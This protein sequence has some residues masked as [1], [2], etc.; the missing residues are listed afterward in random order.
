MGHT[1]EGRPIKIAGRLI[2]PRRPCF[3][4]AEAGVNHNGDLALAKQLVDAAVTAG[5][6]AVKFQTFKAERLAS[7]SAP[8]AAYQLQTTDRSESQL[9]MLRRLELSEPAHR[10][11]MAYCQE[12]RI[13]FLSSPFEEESADVLEQLG[14]CAFK[15]PSGELTNLP[16]LEHVARKGKP[17]IVS[18]GMS[19]L[20]EVEQAVQAIR[21]MK[22]SQVVLLHCV[23]D[24]PADP[25][26]ANLRAMQTMADAFKVPVGYSDH[27]P[28]IEVALAAV[29]LGACV[30]EKHFTCDR[31][32]PGPDHRASLEPDELRRL[33]QGIRMV[34]SALGDGRKAPVPREANT[35]A[36]ARKSLVAARDIPAGSL[37]TEESIAIKRPGTGLPPA[38]LP[39]LVGRKTL[40][41]IPVDT[42]LTLETVG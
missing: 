25:S 42:L 13:L 40:R 2:G 31:T 15:I 19:T 6:D 33:V 24:Y 36:V 37:L 14:V 32:L 7:A 23:S 34:E 28:G 9:E 38:M 29:A 17:M 21:Q 8:K 30:I 10:A 1:R 16:F 22:N 20:A 12:W 26:D 5:A 3:I 41:D 11:L 27:T 18:T 35:A 39:S 4:I